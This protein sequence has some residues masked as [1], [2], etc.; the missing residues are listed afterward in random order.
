MA[1]IDPH[2]NLYA[3]APPMQRFLAQRRSVGDAVRCQR[4][5]V[6][7]IRA[8]VDELLLLGRQVSATSNHVLPR[9]GRCLALP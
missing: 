3:T 5:V 2:Q 1:W 8:R 4:A 7:K 6:V 9:R